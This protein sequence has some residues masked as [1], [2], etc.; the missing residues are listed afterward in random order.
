MGILLQIARLVSKASYF[1]TS[2]AICDILSYFIC[3]KII[4]NSTTTR[5]I[6]NSGVIF[7]NLNT[8][9]IAGLCLAT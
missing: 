3:H 2:N 5:G 6:P 9:N 7:S 1:A 4:R 8:N